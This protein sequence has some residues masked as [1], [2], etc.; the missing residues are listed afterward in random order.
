MQVDQAGEDEQD[1]VAA[2][3]GDTWIINAS[4]PAGGYQ[5]CFQSGTTDQHGIIT[6]GQYNDP[7]TVNLVISDGPC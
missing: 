6:L 2:I 1:V 7:T 5:V 4:Q 3:N